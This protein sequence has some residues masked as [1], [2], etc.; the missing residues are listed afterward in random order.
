[1]IEDEEVRRNLAAAA[2]R[3]WERRLQLGNG[4]NVSARCSRPDRMLVTASGVRSVIALPRLFGRRLRG[5]G[6]GGYRQAN[7]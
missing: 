5:R 6:V 3:A 2:H 4:G 1:M 7:P